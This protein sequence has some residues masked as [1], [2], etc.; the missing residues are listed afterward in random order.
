MS[1]HLACLG[2]GVTSPQ[3]LARL[4]A[5]VTRLGR[6]V[7]SDSDGV[8]TFAWQDGSGAR[9]VYDVLG[10]QPLVLPSFRGST[11]YAF[12]ELRAPDP[13]VAWVT[14]Q[15]A[16]QDAT[17][18][19]TAELE[20]RRHPSALPAR[21]RIR[22][23]GLGINVESF[24]DQKAFLASEASLLGTVEELGDPP[25]EVIEQGLAWPPRMSSS[26]FFPDGYGEEGTAPSPLAL[27]SGVVHDAQ[28]LTN[29]LTEQD[30]VLARA[31]TAFGE[32]DVLLS[33]VEHRF[34]AP[35]QVIAG[36]VSMVGSVLPP[37]P[38]DE[39]DLD[40]PAQVLDQPPAEVV[41]QP[42]T[43]AHDQPSTEDE[44]PRPGETRREW[45]ARTGR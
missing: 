14:V 32:L 19:L 9:V 36:T 7:V 40:P 42:S 5:E 20:Q 37:L 30:F 22:L 43:E 25:A 27:M 26:A 45:R 35:G 6:E 4:V 17:L 8:A 23:C 2:M 1:S 34:V 29:S 3:E 21:G 44:R 38:V 28:I 12:S 41:D 10:S 24:E 11:V 15:R 13:D 39:Q 31:L 33:A 18:T 16:D